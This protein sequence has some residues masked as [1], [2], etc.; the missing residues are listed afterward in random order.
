MK[1]TKS[2]ACLLAACSFSVAVTSCSEDP[3]PVDS[4]FD[5]TENINAAYVSLDLSVAATRADDPNSTPAENE[6]TSVDIYIFNAENTLEKIHK[7]LTVTNNKIEKL[8]TTPALKPFTP[9]VQMPVS[10]SVPKRMAMPMSVVLPVSM[11]D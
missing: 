5:Q 7:S 8:E 10:M 2:S 9:S 4:I 3:N 11:P 1:L 6:I